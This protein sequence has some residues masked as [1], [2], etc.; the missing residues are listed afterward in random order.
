MV[1]DAPPVMIFNLQ[2]ISLLPWALVGIGITPFILMLLR[3]SR[4]QSRLRV[5]QAAW[6]SGESSQAVLS[7]MGGTPLASGELGYRLRLLESSLRWSQGEHQAAWRL[8]REAHQ[9]RLSPIHRWTVGIYMAW[10]ERHESPTTLRWGR[11]LLHWIPGMPHVRHLLAQIAL[12]HEGESS[13]VWDL[14]VGT[15]PLAQDDP[16]LLQDLMLLALKRIEASRQHPVSLGHQEWT[17]QVPFVFEEALKLLLHQHGTPQTHWDRSTPANHLLQEGR[18]LEALVVE[19]SAHRG[20]RSRLLCETEVMALHRIGDT[21]GAWFALEASLVDHPL[22][23][24]LWMERFHGALN[25]GNT[26]LAKE[27]LEMAELCLPPDSSHPNSQEWR[28]HRAAFAHRVDQDDD[29]AW[30]L[31]T[32]L[33][34]ALQEKNAHL[35]TQILIALERYQEAQEQ[36]QIAALRHPTDLELQMLQAECLAGTGTWKTLIPFLD[37]LPPEARE[38]SAF[39]H[40]RGLAWAHLEDPHKARTDLEAAARLAPRELRVILDAGHASADLGDHARAEEHWRQ[41]L[42]LAPASQEAL[43]QMA[44]TRHAQHDPEGA[45]RFLREC[46]LHNPDDESAQAFLAELEAN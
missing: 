46:L 19:R 36:L 30:K 9:C 6:I 42:H 31:L 44:C 8:A 43:Y 18:Y 11:I 34:P 45:R 2:P 32:T 16:L 17:P 25:L 37:S 35:L 24:R 28:L 13:W 7:A 3:S 20:R 27:S 1:F 15:I 10:A 23:F 22:S 39:W 12:K 40:F 5:G 14:W 41:A 4:L 21:R 33:P 29:L 38:R 26:A